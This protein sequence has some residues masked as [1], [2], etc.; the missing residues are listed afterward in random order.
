MK[1]SLSGERKRKDQ[2]ALDVF[3]DRQT[4]KLLMEYCSKNKLDLA[5]GFVKAT[6]RG[7]KFFRAVYYREMKQD[8]LLVKEQAEE[9]EKD[10]KLLRQL[11]DE[12]EKFRKIL[13]T[14]LPRGK[15]KRK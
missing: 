15:R 8:Y 5:T 14:Y 12:N 6:E 13:N 2:I 11:V 7:M 1:L 9:Y 10:N 4:H 3:L